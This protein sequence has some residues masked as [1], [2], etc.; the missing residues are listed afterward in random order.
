MGTSS[1]IPFLANRAKLA[2]LN[3]ALPAL[4]RAAR[5]AAAQLEESVLLMQRRTTG[6][7]SRTRDASERIVVTLARVQPAVLSRA[8]T[9]LRMLAGTNY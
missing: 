4:T 5:E 7:L 6:A 9:R 2:Q 1:S 3:D 8:C